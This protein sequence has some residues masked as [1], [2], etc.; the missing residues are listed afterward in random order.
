MSDSTTTKK[1][2]AIESVR[3]YEV[4]PPKVP[5]YLRWIYLLDSFGV[6]AHGIDR[7][8][9]EER[10]EYVNSTRN[11][12]SWQFFHTFGLWVAACGGLTSMSSFFLPT[13]VFG[14]N[15]RDSMV[16]GI[17]SMNLGC[18]VAAYFSTMGSKSGCRQIVGARLLFGTWGVKLVSVICIVGGV[19]WSVVNC[20]VGGQVF[21]AV[22]GAPLDVGI[23]IISVLSVV[24][25]VFGIKVL[26][27]FQ[28]ILSLPIIIAVILFYVV[29]CDKAHHIP[30]SN[31]LIKDLGYSLETTRGNWLSFFTIGYS[32]T[33]SW[34]SGASDYYAMFP[35]DTS[36]F[37]V[38]FL[39]F[40]GLSIPT[41][42]V[43]VVGTLCGTIAYSYQPW[44]TAYNSGGVGGL[45]NET[46][47]KWG[48]FGQFVMIVWYFSLICN[49]IMN[50]YSAA[51][52]FQ[53]L[54]KRLI[55]VPRW[56]WAFLI[57]LIY[58]ALSIA[59]K[60]HFSTI[61]GNF[62]P[63]LAYWISMYITIL[64]LEN[65]LFRRTPKLRKMH[66]REFENDETS[67]D[68]YL[69]NWNNWDSRANTTNG[70]A[71]MSS[72]IVGAVGAVVGMN[73]TYWQGPIARKIGAYG[74]DIGFWL[75]MAFT[76][77]IYPPLR[78]L[79]LKRFGK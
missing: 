56:C 6:E 69:F 30:A 26:I 2:E 68:K 61:I 17:I 24:I 57:A 73:Q 13:L 52:E 48:R 76:A 34:G 16:S 53:L 63:M 8:T 62:L 35:E 36:S 45:M 1:A 32:V 23:V 54:D 40:L 49:N 20:V 21:A 78:Y 47:D 75:C 55:Y 29:V 59:G 18:A 50:T 71:A 3:T 77:V 74:G 10:L 65:V 67:A 38:Y 41:T 42:L 15:L 9:P 66:W 25:A 19:G 11:G 27:R 51:F 70:F 33:A 46:F 72:F 43:A 4:I 37:L 39:T 14:L 28:T 79:E 12:R 22:S 60:E 64:V 5:K 7:Y 58:F 44:L 31:K